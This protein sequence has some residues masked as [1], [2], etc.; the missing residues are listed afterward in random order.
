MPV[1]QGI[2]FLE[3]QMRKGCKCKN[4]ALMSGDF[5]EHDV[6][7][8]KAIG[9]ILLRKPFGITE[10]FERIENVEK[11]IDPALFLNGLLI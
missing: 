1:Q 2:D 9:L 6:V 3:G 4:M 5:T 10:I 8:A 7:R 11:T